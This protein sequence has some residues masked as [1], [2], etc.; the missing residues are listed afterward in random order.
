MTAATR[1]VRFV[2]SIASSEDWSYAPGQV[3]DLPAE[4]ADAFVAAGIAEAFTEKAPT[5]ASG[6]ETAIR[7]ATE[8]ASLPQAKRRR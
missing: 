5:K 8:D 1:R 7:K 3:A 4:R 2:T 6:A